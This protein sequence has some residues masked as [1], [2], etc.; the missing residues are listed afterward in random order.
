MSDVEVDLATFEPPSRS[1]RDSWLDERAEFLAS[2]LA[3]IARRVTHDAVSRYASTVSLTAAGDPG[4]L[5]GMAAAF[6][7]EAIEFA[8]DYT[9]S[10]YASGELSAWVSATL[11]EEEL[12]HDAGGE[13]VTSHIVHLPPPVE[14]AQEWQN[15]V[16][17]NA[18]EYQ[19]KATNRIVG[20]SDDIWREVR[21][22]TVES[23]HDGLSNEQ[24]KDR[25]EAVTGYS[26]FRADTIGRTETMSAYAGGEMDG[27]RALGEHGPVEKLWLTRVDGRTRKS[28]KE[29]D[30]QVRLLDE[31]FDVGHHQMDRPLDPSAPP[32][33]VVNCRCR[34]LFL[35]VGDRR[36]DGSVVGEDDNA[37]IVAEVAAPPTWQAPETLDGQVGELR[38]ADDQ[39]SLGGAHSKVVLVDDAGNLYLFKYEPNDWVSHA[40]AAS[41]EIAKRAG[42]DVPQ[43]GITSFNGQRGTIQPM[44]KGA[45]AP[46]GKNVSQHAFDPTKISTADIRQIQQHG[47]VDWLVGNNDGHA[48]QYI[49]IVYAK[50]G[51]QLVGIDKGQAFKFFDQDRLD[52]DYHPNSVYGEARPAAKIIDQAYAEGRLSSKEWGYYRH[53]ND[54]A[55]MIDKL[56]AIP[57]D[58]YRS[59]LRVYAEG[60]YPGDDTAVDKFLDA[61]VARKNDLADDIRRYHDRLYNKNLKVRKAQAPPPRQLSVAGPGGPRGMDG[62]PI[63]QNSVTWMSKNDHPMS[64]NDRGKAGFKDVQGWTGGGS[65]QWGAPM[66][67]GKISTVQSHVDG[68][69]R[70]M[71]PVKGDMIVTRGVRA[72]EMPLPPGG[73]SALQGS[74]LQDP[75]F[76]STSAAKVGGTDIAPAFMRDTVLKIRLNEGVGR[77]AYVRPISGFASEREFLVDRNSLMYVHSVRRPNADDIKA[78]LGSASWIVDCEIVDRD[79]LIEQ[80]VKVWNTGTGGGYVTP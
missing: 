46:F 44:L 30:E 53:K 59:M 1:D 38:K 2:R 19:A 43:V 4:A 9:A 23:L 60:R 20:A 72:S 28:H 31:P 24:L 5:D 69:D 74:V 15:V 33:E 26:E 47:I 34:V 22:R 61:A 35:Y 48:N 29:A 54:V 11:T 80:G 49:R 79:W 71:Q 7:T 67:R 77:G 3:A 42:L 65:S 64:T 78:G 41:A 37:P 12:L 62:A 52:V 51:G 14:F 8:G 32:E 66:R 55:P 21:T 63:A 70:W 25:I 56:Q 17:V 76:L 57:D 45:R 18:V 36:P 27:A 6:N 73:L 58:E 50:D 16:N 39:P 10:M 68:I 75:A 40:E 13:F